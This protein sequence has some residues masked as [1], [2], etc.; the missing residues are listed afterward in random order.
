[1]ASSVGSRKRGI[2]HRLGWSVLRTL[3]YGRMRTTGRK[4]LA[5]ENPS[6][7][8]GL[9]ELADGRAMMER[10][11]T[12]RFDSVENNHAAAAEHFEIDAN[13][14][15]DHFRQSR[16]LGEEDASPRDEILHQ[17]DIL[18]AEAALNDIGL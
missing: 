13:A 3:R 6:Q 15:G 9:L 4:N 17:R 12:L 11:V 7:K 1:M 8:A 2:G 14:A 10:V 18:A 5:Q 16:A